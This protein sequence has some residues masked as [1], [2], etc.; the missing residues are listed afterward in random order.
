MFS[1]ISDCTKLN[2]CPL[3]FGH[4]GDPPSW[5]TLKCCWR[6]RRS[7]KTS[8][9][10]MNCWFTSHSL[11]VECKSN[12][13]KKNASFQRNNVT[14]CWQSCEHR[15]YLPPSP[16]SSSYVCKKYFVKGLKASVDGVT[17]YRLDLVH[18]WMHFTQGAACPR[19]SLTVLLL[20]FC[21]CY[22]W[23]PLQRKLS[24]NATSVE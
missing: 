2:V 6:V 20:Y 21:V 23:R 22:T 13:N 7:K 10:P 5:T 9:Q 19:L 18:H 12:N 15:V 14:L 3:G 17:T 24:G 1:F 8:I 16:H 4:A 11:E